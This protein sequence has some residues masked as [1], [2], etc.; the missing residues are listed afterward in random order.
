MH[1]AGLVVLPV[2]E[3]ERHPYSTLNTMLNKTSAPSV[4]SLEKICSGFGITL[5]QFFTDESELAA[6]TAEQRK[7]LET[8]DRLSG[9]DRAKALSFLEFLI[10]QNQK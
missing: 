9:A 2:G 1:G 4:G 6:L 8:W 3:G 10:Q 7:L 5:S